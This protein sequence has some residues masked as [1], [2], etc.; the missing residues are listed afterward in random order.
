MSGERSGD[1]VLRLLAPYA[2]L[3]E[4]LGAPPENVDPATGAALKVDYSPIGFT[5]A[6]LPF[7][8]AL[9]KDESLRDQVS[10]LRVDAVRARLGG[11]TNYYDQALILFGQGWH[12]QQY[13]FD[14][15]GRLL[16]K[17]LP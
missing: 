4:T 5:G 1:G 2:A 12:D 16:A 3:I 9:E 6:V 13:R 15:Q 17:R 11:A 14:E 7:L 10:R 8:A